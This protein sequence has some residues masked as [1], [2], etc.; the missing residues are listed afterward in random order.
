MLLECNFQNQ[1]NT[2]FLFHNPNVKLC[3]I[4]ETVYCCAR[5]L[6]IL[7]ASSRKTRGSH[8]FH[9][10]C[11]NQTLVLQAQMTLKAI[12]QCT[13]QLHYIDIAWFSKPLVKR[14]QTPREEGRE[15]KFSF[16]FDLP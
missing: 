4:Y 13:R 7:L 8:W 2:F 9:E 1:E 15:S 14:N 12:Q 3:Q 16:S 11:R 10:S 5:H 6:I